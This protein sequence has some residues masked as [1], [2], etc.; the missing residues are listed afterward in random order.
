[1]SNKLVVLLQ[2]HYNVNLDDEEIKVLCWLA[3]IARNNTDNV[4]LDE[5]F[6]DIVGHSKWPNL[7]CVWIHALLSVSIKILGNKGIREIKDWCYA[8]GAIPSKDDPQY[9]EKRDASKAMRRQYFLDCIISKKVLPLLH[10]NAFT[11]NN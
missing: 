8:S 1:M 2:N 11:L 6:K 10:E 5:S 3:H 9:K 7:E 4:N